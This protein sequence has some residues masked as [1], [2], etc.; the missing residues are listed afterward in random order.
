[1]H[2]RIILIITYIQ[3]GVRVGL[4]IAQKMSSE[5]QA[6]VF[7]G[8]SVVL[9]PS[10]F[11]VQKHVESQGSRVEPKERVFEW[12]TVAK[13]GG[14]GLFLGSLTSIM[15][16]GGVPLVMSYLALT[17]DCPHHLI[18]VLMLTPPL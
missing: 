13:N 10:F 11:F 6:L 2:V 8:M 3:L 14:F 16:V 18:Q 5:L 15:G 9:I 1:M 12:I 17:T 7:N 4:R